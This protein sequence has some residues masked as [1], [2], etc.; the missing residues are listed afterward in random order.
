MKPS[1]VYLLAT[2]SIIPDTNKFLLQFPGESLIF[3][4]ETCILLQNFEQFCSE[5]LT[6]LSM[7]FLLDSERKSPINKERLM[8]YPNNVPNLAQKHGVSILYWHIVIICQFGDMFLS[9]CHFRQ[10]S[11]PNI[12]THCDSG[13]IYYQESRVTILDNQ[14]NAPKDTGWR[15]LIL[16]QFDTPDFVDSQWQAAPFL[17]SG[18]DWVGESEGGEEREKGGRTVVG[19]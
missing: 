2:S 10:T 13:F 7:Y 6:L 11:P 12:L 15:G 18:Q 5:Y 8:K 17:G 4:Q 3:D 16:P 19:M 9:N 14:K 1:L